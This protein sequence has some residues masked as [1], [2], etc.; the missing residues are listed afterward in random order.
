MSSLQMLC[1]SDSK[2]SPS[3]MYHLI[4][5]N[6]IRVAYFCMKRKHL[7]NDAKFKVK[8][9]MVEL[10]HLKIKFSCEK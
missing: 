6:T 10:N 5:D 1:Y 8:M 9:I 3:P 7:L 2:V 4:I